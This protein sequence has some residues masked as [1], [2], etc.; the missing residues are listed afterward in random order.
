MRELKYT[1]HDGTVI[2]LNADDLWV[3]DLQ[4]MRGYAWTYT[5]ATRGIKSV[6]RNASTAKM[7]VRTTDPSRLDVVQTAFD[8]DVQA[9]TPGML[10]VDGEWFQRAYVVGSS[11]GLV[12]WPEYA[13]TDYT[14]VLCDGVWRRALPVQHFFPTA[15]GTGSQLDLPTDLPT[16]LGTSRIAMF[17]S[18]PG[19][20]PAEF[21]ATIFGPCSDPAFTIGSNVYKVSDVAVPS[22]GYIAL[23]ATGLEK[24]IKLVAANGDVTNIFSHGQR[25]SGTGGGKYIFE[26][27]PAGDSLLEI[28][29]NFGIDLTIYQQSGGVPWSTLS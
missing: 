26:P 20:Q 15:A 28:S 27:I 18:N 13:Q 14:I 16:D 4:E 3:A 24:S 25:G 2:D 6:S 29:S 11:L 7:T 12:P 21:T 17:V 9:V 10:T 19:V 8:S 22:G 23:S 5:L 1:S